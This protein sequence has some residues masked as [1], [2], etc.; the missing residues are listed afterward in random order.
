MGKRPYEK[1]GGVKF[2]DNPLVDGVTDTRVFITDT[3]PKIPKG[4]SGTYAKGSDGNAVLITASRTVEINENKN[5]V[6]DRKRRNDKMPNDKN[7]NKGGDRNQGGKPFQKTFRSYHN[8][9]NE[10]E[11]AAFRQGAKTNENKIKEKLGM[12][13]PKK[14]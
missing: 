13:P 12:L 3:S 7:T 1:I 5:S 10:G 6:I 14:P 4:Y 8:E 9:M 11:K 2:Y